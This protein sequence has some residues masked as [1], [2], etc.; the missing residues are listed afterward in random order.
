MKRIA[1]LF[2]VLATVARAELTPETITTTW[3]RTD[4]TSTLTTNAYLAG[5]TYRLTNCIAYVTNGVRQDLSLLA[6]QIR[7]GDD[8][9]NLLWYGSA[10]TLTTGVFSADFRFPTWTPGPLYGYTRSMGLQL[11]LVDVTNGVS[12]TYNARK[13][14]TVT[15]PMSGGGLGTITSTN[16][17]NVIESVPSVFGRTGPIAAVAGDYTADQ[18]GAI[19]TNYV[20]ITYSNGLLWVDAADAGCTGFVFR[21]SGTNILQ[22]F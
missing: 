11:T 10:S 17:I 8:R 21:V 7:T 1:A 18:V 6:V 4:V 15:L 2:L 20:G 14:V 22:Q 3:T 5:V 9:T 12:M 16:L 19:A 13:L